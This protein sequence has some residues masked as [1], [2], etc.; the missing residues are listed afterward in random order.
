MRPSPHDIDHELVSA[1]KVAASV[2]GLQL[3]AP[4]LLDIA[5]G[6][7]IWVEG[8]LPDFGGSRGMIFRG[9][10]CS[11]P[12]TDLYV[13]LISDAYRQFDRARFVETLSDWGWY[14]AA[15]ERPGW[16]TATG[17]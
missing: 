4:Y 12:P 10:S 17:S 13:S 11:A 1:W 14:G 2:L 5:D 6:T 15:D 9:I 7:A 16:L 3:V 8:F